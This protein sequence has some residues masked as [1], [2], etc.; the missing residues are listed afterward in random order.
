[1]K[2][3]TLILLILIVI[4]LAG[5]K[6]SDNISGAFHN[7]FPDFSG[8]FGS[9][10]SIS[11]SSVRVVPYSGGTCREYY[12]WGDN[13]NTAGYLTST[14]INEQSLESTDVCIGDEL[15]E[16]YCDSSSSDGWGYKTKNY[17]CGQNKCKTQTESGTGRVMGYCEN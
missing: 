8:I 7:I 11:S 10:S 16:R 1:M 17:N 12:D 14:K 5:C 15:R 6:K 2:K 4:F 3:Q 9:L 13:K